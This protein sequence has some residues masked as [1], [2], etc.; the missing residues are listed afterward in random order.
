[1]VVSWWLFALF[2]WLV[3]LVGDYCGVDFLVV[4]VLVLRFFGRCGCC[5][6]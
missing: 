4:I 3:I 6:R 1:M 2:G 5:V